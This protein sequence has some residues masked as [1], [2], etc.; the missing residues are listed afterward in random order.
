MSMELERI[1]G[2]IPEKREAENMLSDVAKLIATVDYMAV[3][4]Y[5]EIFEE[6]EAI[7]V[8]IIARSR[9]MRPIS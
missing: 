4:D 8:L 7:S 5:P 2:T 1:A 9:L 3:C 6:E